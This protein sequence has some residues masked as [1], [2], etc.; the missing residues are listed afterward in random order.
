[1]FRTGSQP[2]YPAAFLPGLFAGLLAC[3]AA[4]V[5]RDRNRG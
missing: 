1:M 3:A 2:D 5:T 4:A